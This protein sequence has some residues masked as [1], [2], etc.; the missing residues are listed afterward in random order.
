MFLLLLLSSSLWAQEAGVFKDLRTYYNACGVVGK[1]DP[2]FEACNPP[3]MAQIMTNFQ[4]DPKNVEDMKKISRFHMTHSLQV[5]GKMSLVA[6]YSALS[7]EKVGKKSYPIELSR[8]KDAWSYNHKFVVTLPPSCKPTPKTSLDLGQK[9]EGTSVEVKTILATIEGLRSYKCP[10]PK[11]GF[12]AFAVGV[13]DPTGKPDVWMINEKNEMKQ[14]RS[15][16]GRT[17]FD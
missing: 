16:T 11:Q 6:I 7:T 4:K 17:P 15:S 14:I 8:F 12:L 9:I 5:T 10:D 1:D 3:N 2:R 13:V